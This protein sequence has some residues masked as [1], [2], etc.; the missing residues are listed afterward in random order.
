MSK[1]YEF[2]KI[3]DVAFNIAQES[4]S[5]VLDGKKYT[6]AKVNDWIETIGSETV[7]RLRETSPNFKYIVS[8]LILSK[9]GAGL[10]LETC[11]F[12]DQKTD[13]S[14]TCRFENDTLTCICTVIGVAI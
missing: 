10:H 2:S 13:G 12:W 5:G 14:I 7:A 4:I 1:D 11:T 9:V 3:S 6:V 8:V